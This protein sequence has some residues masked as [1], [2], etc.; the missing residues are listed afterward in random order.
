MARRRSPFVRALAKVSHANLGRR[1][2]CRIEKFGFVA[3]LVSRHRRSD[4]HDAFSASPS[5]EGGAVFG[6]RRFYSTESRRINRASQKRP[7]AKERRAARTTFR[8]LLAYFCG[9]VTLTSIFV[10]RPPNRPPRQAKNAATITIKNIT[11]TAT[12]PVL[13]PP[14]PLSPI[15][16]AS[17][18][19]L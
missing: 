2:G 13:P 16:S 4:R 12:T 8:Q 1:S 6:C 5:P 17:C 18:V 10:F 3:D 11:N 7:L 15:F 19:N 9:V 14:P